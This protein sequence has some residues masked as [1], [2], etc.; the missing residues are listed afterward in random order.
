MQLNMAEYT[1]TARRLNHVFLRRNIRKV[2]PK[3]RASNAIE[4]VLT[5]NA[6]LRPL[7][8]HNE[9]VLIS[10]KTAKKPSKPK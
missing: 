6:Q 10:F 1:S 8:L 7:G 2:V 9:D 3:Y 5:E 4:M